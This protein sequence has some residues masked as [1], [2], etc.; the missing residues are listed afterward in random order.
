[1]KKILFILNDAPYANEKAYN[2]LRMAM[3]LKKE[4]APID[5]KVFLFADS[6]ACALPNQHTPA[7]YYN[8]E[9]MIHG[10]IEGNGQVKLCKS[11]AEARGIGTL[12]LIPGTMIGT[13][14]ELTTW[15]MDADKVLTF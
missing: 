11:C 14:N 9:K 13:L 5:I 8:I 4:H 6:I 1:M 12:E 3:N 2:A 7:G 15:V 10:I